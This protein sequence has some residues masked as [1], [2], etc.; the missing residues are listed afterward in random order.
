[1]P[2]RRCRK[3]AV[4]RRSAP[5]GGKK[6]LRAREGFSVSGGRGNESVDTM[7]TVSESFLFFVGRQ[8]SVLYLINNSLA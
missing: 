6:Q 1:M 7:L 4:I 3:S 8:C 5:S 2:T